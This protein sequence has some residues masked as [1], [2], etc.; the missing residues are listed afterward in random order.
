MKRS[1]LQVHDRMTEEVYTEPLRTFR[2]ATRPAAVYT[3]PV[4]ERGR[5]A[6]EEINAEL[7]LAFDEQVSLCCV[8]CH[9]A[10]LACQRLSCK[11]RCA[12]SGLFITWSNISGMSSVICF[13]LGCKAALSLHHTSQFTL[14][15]IKFY[16]TRS[17]NL[18]ACWNALL[19]LSR[20]YEARD[21][22]A[23]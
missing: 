2:S 13:S 19:E 3:V 20:V 15:T 8:L 12:D 16:Y 9:G 5:A 7:G 4:L 14:I 23:S 11:G 18:S 22:L 21:S 1:G 17:C 6:L 10:S